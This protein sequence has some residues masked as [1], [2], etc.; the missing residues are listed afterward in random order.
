MDTETEDE[1]IPPGFIKVLSPYRFQFSDLIAISATWVYN[2]V[3]GFARWWDQFSDLC[4]QHAMYRR[5]RVDMRA[6][7][8]SV[9]KDIAVL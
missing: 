3:D 4:I 8:T 7:K 2:L 9:L 6:F 5:K 1:E